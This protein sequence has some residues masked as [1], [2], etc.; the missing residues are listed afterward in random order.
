MRL[1]GEG[2]VPPSP[3]FSYSSI[4][5]PQARRRPSPVASMR[6]PIMARAQAGNPVKGNSPAFARSCETRPVPDFAAC[7]ASACSSSGFVS[8]G[9]GAEDGPGPLGAPYCDPP[10]AGGD[11]GVPWLPGFVVVGVVPV[12]VV[13]GVVPVVVVVV[14]V[15]SLVVVVSV[16]VVVVVVVDV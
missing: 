16:G 7:S 5:A 15:V 2:G 4:A 11:G 3:R 6:E 9:F 8:G 14:V 10:F 12:V 1:R 13:V